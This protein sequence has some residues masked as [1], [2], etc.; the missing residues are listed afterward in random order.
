MSKTLNI[1]QPMAL[2]GL[3]LKNR[4]VKAAMSE[5]LSNTAG[6]VTPELLQLYKTWA[7]GGVGCAI[8]GNVMID[9][10]AKNEAG[11]V[12]IEDDSDLTALTQWAAIGKKQHMP[13]IVQLSHPGK[14]CPKGL[15]KETV[16]PSAIGYN[17][18]MAAVFGVP[19]EM[20]DAEIVEQIQ[21]FGESARICKLAGFEGVQIHAAHGYL[22]SSF[23]SP[24]HNQRS[25]RWGGSLE[26]RM[27]FLIESFQEI[28]RQTGKNFTVGVKLNSSDFQK[29]GFS[30]EDSLAVVKALDALGVDFIEISGGTYEAAAMVGTKK[31][32]STVQREAYFLEFAETIRSQVQTTLM[33][34]GGF[35]TRKGMDA[36]LQSGACDLI[37]MARPLAVETDAPARLIAGHDVQY[38][39]KPIKTGIPFFDNMGVMELIWYAAQFRAIGRGLK[40]N[41]HL[42][43]LWVFALYVKNSIKAIL[44]KKPISGRLRAKQ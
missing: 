35:R 36:A 8:T 28:R 17:I 4:L 29:G 20:T 41:P 26:N 9:I 7:Q 12:V 3:T 1:T 44:K 19:R 10:R 37:G 24:K 42:R 21:R 6:Q 30:E 34:T 23:L 15:N 43:P 40:P 13:L 33:V 5:A 38:A 31:K 39:V 16:A 2:Q 18:D 32:A 25:D 22:V 11:V 27:R 14:Q